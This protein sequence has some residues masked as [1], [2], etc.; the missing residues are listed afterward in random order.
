MLNKGEAGAMVFEP[1]Y[2]KADVGDTVK[3]V[4]T[5]K[6]HNAESVAEAWPEGAEP[7]KGKMNEEITYKVEKEGLYVIKC[8]PHYGMGMVALVQA[9]KPVNLDKVKDFKALGKA[10]KRLSDELAKVTQ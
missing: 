9:G 5:D 3:F 6:G 8:L 1:A 7:L 4:P 2:V 10:K